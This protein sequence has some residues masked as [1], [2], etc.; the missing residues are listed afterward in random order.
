[1]PLKAALKEV[2]GKI[3]SGDT[4]VVVWGIVVV[5]AVVL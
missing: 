2:R 5:V 3:G 4:C 1:M